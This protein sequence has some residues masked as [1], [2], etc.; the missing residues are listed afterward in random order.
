MKRYHLLMLLFFTLRVSTAQIL[1]GTLTV[2]GFP[3]VVQNVGDLVAEAGENDG[4]I[5]FESSFDASRLA[6]ILDSTTEPLTGIVLTSSANCSENV[7]RYAVYVHTQGAP[8][9]M[10]VEAKTF[11]NSGIRY[12]QNALYDNLP[13]QP[14]GPRDLTPENGGNY[15]TIPNDGGAA[16]KVFEFVGCREEIPIQFRVRAS[17]LSANEVSNFQVFYT[18]VASLL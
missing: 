1:P 12:P 8:A 14:L 6:F 11:F 18:V 7:F 2:D 9:G 5:G 17:A 3:N 16:I 13:I 10:L 15:I 4:A